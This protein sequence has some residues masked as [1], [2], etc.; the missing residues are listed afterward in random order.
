MRYTVEEVNRKLLM[1]REVLLF[2]PKYYIIIL[3]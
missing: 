3:K 2:T 1:T